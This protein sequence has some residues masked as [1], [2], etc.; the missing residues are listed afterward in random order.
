M[1]AATPVTVEAAVAVPVEAT[2]GDE[3]SALVLS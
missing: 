1:D 3:V 2:A